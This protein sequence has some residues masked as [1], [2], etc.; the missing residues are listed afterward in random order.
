MLRTQTMRFFNEFLRLNLTRFAPD[1]SL[2]YDLLLECYDWFLANAVIWF[3][4][5]TR[6]SEFV[7]TQT[8]GIKVV[9]RRISLRAKP[10]LFQ[11]YKN[12]K[13]DLHE[14]LTYENKKIITLMPLKSQVRL[15]L[16]RVRFLTG[17]FAWIFSYFLQT[18]FLAK[19]VIWLFHWKR[20][21]KKRK[22]CG[23]IKDILYYLKSYSIIKISI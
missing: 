16:A 14:Y 11:T 4:S 6:K 1:D 5:L 15:R 13:T 12:Q 3:V 21:W 8:Y 10:R 18:I 2:S 9:T 17:H 7:A 22:N 19:I 20:E 23:N